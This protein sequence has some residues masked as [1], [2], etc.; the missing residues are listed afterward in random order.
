MR[1]L[2]GRLSQQTNVER[3]ALRR[4]PRR[5]ARDQDADGRFRR[6]GVREVVDDV[7]MR[8]V[9]RAGRRIVAV[10]LLGHGRA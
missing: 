1:P 7:R 5:E 2:C 6:V 3:P 4:A 8:C 9:E 10:A